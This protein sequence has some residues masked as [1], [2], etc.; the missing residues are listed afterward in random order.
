[1]L[2][3]FHPTTAVCGSPRSGTAGVIHET[4]GTRKWNRGRR[5]PLIIDTRSACLPMCLTITLVLAIPVTVEI[6]ISIGNHLTAWRGTETL[7]RGCSASKASTYVVPTGQRPLALS[8]CPSAAPACG[9]RCHQHHNPVRYLTRTLGMTCR[10][11]ACPK[12]ASS[13]CCRPPRPGRGS[14]P[15]S[16]R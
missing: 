2:I 15:A 14:W 6:S 5:L 10:V 1:M 3:S 4:T 12:D 7:R 11:P 13:G 9:R 16:Q 8:P